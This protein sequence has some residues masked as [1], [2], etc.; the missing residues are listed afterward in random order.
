MVAWPGEDILVLP[1]LIDDFFL[2]LGV[3]PCELINDGGEEFFSVV[4]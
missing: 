3:G 2:V 4:S 1:E